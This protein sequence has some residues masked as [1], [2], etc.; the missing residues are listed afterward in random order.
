[1]KNI[2]YFFKWISRNVLLLWLVSLLTDLSSQMVFPLIPLFLTSLGAG[3][4]IIGIVEWAAD[5]TA[6]LLKVFSWYLSDK[7]KKRKIFVLI[8]Y[9]FSTIT[10]PL[11]ALAKTWP[12]VLVFRV[13]ERIGKWLRD[14]PRDALVADATAPEFMGKAYGIQRAMDGTGSVLWALL[15]LVLFPYLWYQNLF[16]FAFVPWLI[17]VIAILFVKE[18]K[19]MKKENHREH[20]HIQPKIVVPWLGTSIKDLPKNLKL[21]ILVSALFWL[22]NFWYAF[23]L[24]K[25]KSVGASD[26]NAI[27]YYVLFYGIYTLISAPAG[28]ISDRIGRKTMLWVAYSLFLVVT[29]WLA[30][31]SQLW[32]IICLFVLF[33]LLFAIVDGTERALVVD[34]A[35][36]DQKGTAL[37]IFHTAIGIVSLPGWYILWMLWDKFSPQATFLFAF[38][39]GLIIMILFTFVNT[40][41]EPVTIEKQ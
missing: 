3:A 17:G 38:C 28:I 40:T 22:V 7:F 24:L 32:W 16:L 27:L 10:K 26:Q 2:K 31:T 15:A 11:F 25:A 21:F 34:L 41:K 9:S 5:T 4:T 23:M 8:G 37:G 39:I 1:M 13:I 20:V 29:L 35:G 12:V 14:A 19:T 18:A 36:K 30:L 6:A 33:W